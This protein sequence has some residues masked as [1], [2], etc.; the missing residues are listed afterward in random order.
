[1]NDAVRADVR[2]EM[3]R[4]EITQRALASRIGWNQEYLS[5]RLTGAVDFTLTDVE[6]L[7]SALNVKFI[8]LAARHAGTGV[9]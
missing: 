4:Q 1:M 8:Q 7:G 6:M 5:R 3:A 9:R 2:A